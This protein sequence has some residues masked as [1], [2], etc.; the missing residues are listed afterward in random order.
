MERHKIYIKLFNFLLFLPCK[1]QLGMPGAIYLGVARMWSESLRVWS[2]P[3]Y[4]S[5]VSG[6]WIGGLP[7]CLFA[8]CCEA[9]VK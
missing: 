6:A 9:I 4:T 1:I 3:E 8:I 7:R 5:V 2:S